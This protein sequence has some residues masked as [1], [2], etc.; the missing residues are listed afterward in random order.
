MATTRKLRTE[1]DMECVLPIANP[2][3]V[4]L[5]PERLA[6]LEPLISSHIEG[7]RYPGAQFAIARRGRIA[8]ART[9]GRALLEPGPAPATDDTLWLL[10][11]QTK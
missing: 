10:F 2:E 1:R 7:K 5:D 3:A 9:L 4:G 8:L 6:Q 11:S